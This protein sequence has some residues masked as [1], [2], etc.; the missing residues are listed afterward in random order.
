M[1][2]EIDWRQKAETLQTK[3]DA[4]CLWAAILAYLIAGY[5]AYRFLSMFP[6][7]AYEYGDL[8]SQVAWLPLGIGAVWFKNK[9][10][11]WAREE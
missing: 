6:R 3:L 9:L 7:L 11:D 8:V 2:N 10:E 4:V 5:V 1:A